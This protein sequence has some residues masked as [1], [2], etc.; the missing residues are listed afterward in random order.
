[1]HDVQS[2]LLGRMAMRAEGWVESQTPSASDPPM[3]AFTM[4][5]DLSKD[6][7]RANLEAIGMTAREFELWS[8]LGDLGGRLHSLP[9]VHPMERREFAASLHEIGALLLARPAHRALGWLR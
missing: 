2:R 1:L 8:T 3:E 6:A 7:A 9:V 5:S 4:R